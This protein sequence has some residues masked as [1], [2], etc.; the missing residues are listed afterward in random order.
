MSWVDTPWSF[1]LPKPDEIPDCPEELVAANEPGAGAALSEFDSRSLGL[2]SR[3]LTIEVVTHMYG[4]GVEIGR[5][6]PSHP[7]R[8]QGIRGQL[9]AWWRLAC[10][11]RYASTEQRWRREEEIFGSTTF[12]SPLTIHVVQQPDL[13]GRRLDPEQIKRADEIQYALFPAVSPT[14]MGLEYKEDRDVLQAGL[15][16]KLRLTW[17]SAERIARRRIRQREIAEDTS[18]PTEV[19]PICGEIDEALTAWLAFGGYGARTRRGCGAIRS[20]DPPPLSRLPVLP[21]VRCFVPNDYRAEDPVEI[22]A[23]L[24]AV[25]LYRAF[26]EWRPDRRGSGP[27][28]S[29]WPEA[30]SLRKITRQS[31][32]DHIKPVVPSNTIPA[33]PRSALGMP[34]VFH[35]K[36]RGDPGQ[37]Q[38]YPKLHGESE[39]RERMASPVITRPLYHDGRW[40]P[41]L[42][43]LKSD[44]TGYRIHLEGQVTRTLDGAPVV[45][46]RL[47]PLEPMHGRASAI[48]AF[49]AFAQS[50]G[51]EEVDPS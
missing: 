16:F 48:E 9:R 11:H 49:V 28:R 42:V 7:I 14:R 43:F 10:G 35:F 40:V 24:D 3:E 33:F 26:R 45:D 19:T 12:P 13:K 8:A 23:W 38:V 22:N 6:D 2:E 37:I 32:T 41:G 4:G 51:Y 46:E 1:L 39:K 27:G 31:T 29:R 25:D 20:V 5:H 36:D 30:D 34:I 21:G 17:L 47:A 50:R 44:P 15:V 18:I